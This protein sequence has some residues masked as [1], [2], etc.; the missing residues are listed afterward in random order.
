MTK[1]VPTGVSPLIAV[2]A[3]ALVSFLPAPA[4][5]NSI[6]PLFDRAISADGTLHTFQ[7]DFIWDNDVAFFRFELD[8]AGFYDL[9]ASTSSWTAFADS[10]F[11]PVL[12]L[13]STPLGGPATVYEYLGEEG[14]PVAAIFDDI[15]FDDSDLVVNLNAALSLRLSGGV[16]TLALTQ[17]LNY[18]HENLTFDWDDPS[19]QCTVSEGTCDPVFGGLG[20]F[21]AGTVQITPVVDTTPVPEPGTLSL[22]ALGSLATTIIRRRRRAAVTARP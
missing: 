13:Y 19:Y 17:A 9:T 14:V 4:R 16:Y 11:D 5:A 2:L 22:L 8:G 7:G 15:D 10:G 21:F 12:S 18:P 3:L 1:R 20:A 6:E